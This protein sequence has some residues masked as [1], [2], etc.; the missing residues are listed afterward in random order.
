MMFTK[1]RNIEQFYQWLVGFTDGDGSFII[2]RQNNGKKW[3][4]TYKLTQKSSN[5]KILYYIK[6]MLKYGQVST[7]K[8]GNSSYRIRDRKILKK[9]IFPIFDT[10]PLLTSRYCCYSLFKQASN[11]LDSD[12]DSITK[13]SKMEEIYKFYQNRLFLGQTISSKWKNL[14]L[15]HLTK[16]DLNFITPFW[17]S[18]FWEA[19]GCFYIVKKKNK[20]VH[21]LGLSQKFD[22]QVL[23]AIRLIMGSK[24]KV[25]DRRPK[26]EYFSWNSTSYSVC[27]FA[28]RYF[29]RKFI[30][31]SSLQFAIWRR[32]M[33]KDYKT[34]E[35]ARKMLENNTKQK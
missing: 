11:V 18:G 8:D 30:A 16:N 23:E 35:K 22:K 26:Q 17:L 20:Y 31:K 14:N 25:K 10:Y 33:G 21:G 3:N 13:N 24:A 27:Q 4:L 1:F 28:V 29:Y 2:D 15:N 34:L 12:F 6:S 32:S 19:K 5:A 9:V 7:A